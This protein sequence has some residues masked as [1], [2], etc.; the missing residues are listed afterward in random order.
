MTD[1]IMVVDFQEGRK[2]TLQ[3]NTTPGDLSYTEILI[4]RF[5]YMSCYG[6]LL[7]LTLYDKHTIELVF[8]P[9]GPEN[10]D[11]QLLGTLQAPGANWFFNSWLSASYLI[12]GESTLG[13]VVLRVC[14]LATGEV[15]EMSPVPWSERPL[16]AEVY[17]DEVLAYTLHSDFSGIIMID[18]ESRQRLGF[19][20]VP[21]DYPPSILL[22][23]AA[24]AKAS[25]GSKDVI[26]AWWTEKMRGIEAFSVANVSFRTRKVLEETISGPSTLHNDVL[27]PAKA[28]SVPAGSPTGGR[29]SALFS[30]MK[31]LSP[32]RTA[33][34]PFRASENHPGAH[35]ILSLLRPTNHDDFAGMVLGQRGR[36]GAVA[37]APLYVFDGPM[38]ALADEGF[39]QEPIRLTWNAE[40]SVLVQWSEIADR[41]VVYSSEPGNLEIFSLK[42]Y[43]LST[44]SN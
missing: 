13:S 38:Q 22:P 43:E 6:A 4:E 1:R 29:S 15:K 37:H 8:Q 3:K 28:P 5:E 21:S 40:Q 35:H 23:P 42:V 41:V 11:P 19:V 18:I 24:L 32:W 14:N 31:Q 39:K 25:K 26:D 16:I 2:Y 30:L 27:P 9:F 44:W 36:E 12:T 7:V 20:R 17:N 34:R 33:S 10:P